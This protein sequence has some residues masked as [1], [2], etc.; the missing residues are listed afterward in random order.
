MLALCRLVMTLAL[1]PRH[2]LMMTLALRSAL[3]RAAF[4]MCP[5]AKRA[6]TRRGF[7]AVLAVV[8]RAVTRAIA[9]A[10][11]FEIIRAT[12]LAAFGSALMCPNAAN[13]IAVGIA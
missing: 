6:F 8:V 11:A 7:R 4:A 2:R 3:A 9:R 13:A 1:L 10:L 12:V 5:L